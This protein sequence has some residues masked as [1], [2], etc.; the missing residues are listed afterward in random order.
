[1]EI[2]TMADKSGGD[3]AQGNMGMQGNATLQ[4]MNSVASAGAGILE[5]MGGAAAS[6]G[7]ADQSVNQAQMQGN[8]A[9]TG[10]GGNDNISADTT[11]NIL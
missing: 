5:G 9:A 1:L 6:M 11:I 8:M 4:D 10:A 3:V 7:T 2:E